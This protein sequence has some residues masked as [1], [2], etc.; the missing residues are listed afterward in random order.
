MPKKKLKLIRNRGRNTIFFEIYFAA[1]HSYSVDLT[2]RWSLFLSLSPSLMPTFRRE[3][4]REY[5]CVC[6]C[7]CQ[8]E[9]VPF[10]TV[11]L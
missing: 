10:S 1:N 11:A 9:L 6:V 2:G 7:V 3:R 5:V 4:E 8:C